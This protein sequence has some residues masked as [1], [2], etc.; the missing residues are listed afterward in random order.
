MSE[1]QK[2]AFGGDQSLHRALGPVNLMLLGI[3]AVIGAGIF[4]L[5]GTAAAHNAGPGIV[6]SFVIAGTAC[7]LAGLC[8]A[9][10]ASM[11]PISGSAYTYAYATLGEL[12][13]WIIG[14]DL[15]L[16]YS[17]AS[18]TVAI[19]WSGYVVSF[20]NDLGIVIPPE[21]TQPPGRMLVL[22]KGKWVLLNDD[23]IRTL[24]NLPAAQV[25][26]ASEIQQALSGVQHVH[27]IMNLPAM[28]VIVFATVILVIGI[29]ESARTNAVIVVL[30]VA[31]VLIFVCVGAMYVKPGNWSPFIPEN[32]GTWGE[33]G[34]SGVFRGAAVIFFAYIGFDAVSTAA[35]ESK[36]PQRDMPIGILGSLAICTILYILV[37][38][39]LTGL[40]SYKQLNVPDPI[41]VGIDATGITWLAP[42][43]K[44]A[45]IAGLTS[46]ILVLLLGQPRIFYS[47]S[48]DGLLPEW[49]SKVHPKFK[50]PYITT[51]ATGVLVAVGAGL[52]PIDVV[53][54]LVSIGTLFA[55][56]I[57]CGAVLV[58]RVRHPEI[59]RTFRVPFL[60]AVA[61]GGALFCGYLMAS[62]PWETWERLIIWMVIGFVVY[63]LYGIRKSKLAK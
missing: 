31:V 18:A 39:V 30:K 7:G 43:I 62:L 26:T 16:E 4:V 56:V 25:I 21:L 45:A 1:L 54:H 57:V 14:W 6:L 3:G 50:T 35:Q 2:E 29:R 11:L 27:S 28:L 61:V 48:R 34:W 22:L 12:V 63:F 33:F 59:K 8:Y 60:P 15:I 9:E 36:N 52:T 38:A 51:I 17:F 10:F 42:L 44:I 37:S 20:L 55:F 49:F 53:G 47:M 41:A 58:L 40:V 23:L 5:T 46:V 32:T 24:L 13:A 19:G